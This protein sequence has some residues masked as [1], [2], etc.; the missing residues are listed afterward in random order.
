MV[1]LRCD[2]PVQFQV[3]SQNQAGRS[4]EMTRPTLIYDVGMD[5]GHSSK[6]QHQVKWALR[7]HSLQLSRKSDLRMELAIC[8]LDRLYR[9]TRC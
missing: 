3:L 9:S 4:N 7:S 1:H 6:L 5:S 8:P 2:E